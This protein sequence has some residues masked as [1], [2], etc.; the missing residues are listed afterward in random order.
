MAGLLPIVSSSSSEVLENVSGLTETFLLF[1]GSGRVKCS[2]LGVT[3]VMLKVLAGSAGPGGLNCCGVFVAVPSEV[4]FKRWY[5]RDS[6][7][8]GILVI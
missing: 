4:R 6:L 8:S 2:G 7:L 1:F 5:L 3:A